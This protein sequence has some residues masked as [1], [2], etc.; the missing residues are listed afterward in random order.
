MG[1]CFARFWFRFAFINYSRGY[2]GQCRGTTNDSDTF[3]E[4]T[5]IG[6]SRGRVLLVHS[7]LRYQ[8]ILDT[9]V[10]RSF[11]LQRNGSYYGYFYILLLLYLL[12]RHREITLLNVYELLT[13]K[14]NRLIE[15]CCLSTT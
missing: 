6:F 15:V 8:I 5:A 3:E 1:F 10:C 4:I 11:L 7:N 2:A 12:D 13:E 14:A 9:A